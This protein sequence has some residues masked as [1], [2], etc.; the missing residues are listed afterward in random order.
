MKFGFDVQTKMMQLSLDRRVVCW[1]WWWGLWGFRK[2]R[3]TEDTLGTQD[4]DENNPQESE[5]IPEE[6]S[7]RVLDKVQNR[8]LWL[9]LKV[10]SSWISSKASF[11][12]WQSQKDTWNQSE[13]QKHQFIP[14]PL[15]SLPQHKFSRLWHGARHQLV[16][17]TCPRGSW[18]QESVGCKT[19]HLTFRRELSP[20][21]THVQAHV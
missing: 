4:N 12:S 14:P 20:T 7:E 18:P 16:S 11:G 19:G 3:W 10:G 2:P 17:P 8:V 15:H 6:R 9:G 5:T 1:M 13:Q 21:Y